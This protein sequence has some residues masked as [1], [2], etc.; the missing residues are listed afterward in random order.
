MAAGYD[1]KK[2]AWT[3]QEDE[4]LVDLVEKQN[5]PWK[6]IQDHMPERT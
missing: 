5:I 3:S 4:R 1:S 6:H 2:K